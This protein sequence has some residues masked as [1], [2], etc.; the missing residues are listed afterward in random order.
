MED[1]IVKTGTTT[2]AL[3]CKDG[4]VLAADKR[5]TLGGMIVG[6]KDVDKVLIINDNLALT[7]AGGVSDIQLMVKL[8][9]A[10][11]KLD[12][13]RRDRQLNTKEIANLLATMVYGNIRKMSMIPGISAFLLGGKDN[14]GYHTYDI[15]PDG[16]VLPVKD[17]ICDGSGM[18]FATGVLEANYKKNMNIEEGIKLAVKAVNAAIQRDTCSGNGI[19]VVTITNKGARKVFTKELDMT[20]SV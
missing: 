17:Y 14:E 9:K 10:Q 8:L 16:S 5:A 3:V 20:I 1:K 11:M 19:D 6:H 13:I 4:I 7:T 18:M 2:V 15:G 12:E